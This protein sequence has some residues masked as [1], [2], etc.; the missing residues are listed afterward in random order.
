MIEK[1]SQ[2]QDDET[3]VAAI[4]GGDTDAFGLLYDRHCSRLLGVGIAILRNR[5]EAED[6]LHDVFIELWQKASS[7]NPEKSSVEFWLIL[8]MRSRAIDRQRALRNKQHFEDQASLE[9]VP[10][11][12][13]GD[14]L[15]Y[16]E[17]NE[18][19]QVLP[20]T[21]RDVVVL[22]YIQGYSCSEISTLIG[23]PIGTIKS[24]L[25]SALKK[26][27]VRFELAGSGSA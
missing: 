3:L 19:M 20:D 15:E 26:M 2:V 6:L 25:Q 17:L 9:P 5:R 4:A 27:R 21:Q 10:I 18:A 16:F 13:K 14:E 1:N 8:R 22:N 11:S 12:T 24:R 23:V 7:Y